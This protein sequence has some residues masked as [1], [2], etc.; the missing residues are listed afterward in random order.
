MKAAVRHVLG[1][2]YIPS[3]TVPSAF[4]S[5]TVKFR[6]LGLDKLLEYLDTHWLMGPFPIKSWNCFRRTTRTNN[7]CEGWHRRLNHFAQEGVPAFYVLIPLLYREATKLR[8]QEVL[9]QEGKLDRNQRPS[10]R[11]RER[12][13]QDLWDQYEDGQ[14]D[15]LDLLHAVSRVPDDYDD[16]AA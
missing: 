6:D 13:L 12:S 8:M 4:R 5:L 2:P 16:D 15:V 7:D 1:L 3:A 11:E 14:L 10:V 9:V